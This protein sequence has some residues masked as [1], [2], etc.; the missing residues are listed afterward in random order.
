M[1]NIMVL[2]AINGLGQ[3]ISSTRSDISALD[4]RITNVNNNI[5][6]AS[7]FDHV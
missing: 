6:N 3:D 4:N 1:D 2:D 7:A 5:N